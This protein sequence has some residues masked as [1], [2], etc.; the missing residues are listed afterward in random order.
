[1]LLLVNHLCAQLQQPLS[2]VQQL[3]FHR[4]QLLFQPLEALSAGWQQ[5]CQF[6]QSVLND[7]AAPGGVQRQQHMSEW[8]PRAVQLVKNHPE[9]LLVPEGCLQQLL[10]QQ[11][12]LL[13]LSLQEYAAGVVASGCVLQLQVLQARGLEEG[14]LLGR[15]QQ[16]LA[17]GLRSRQELLWLMLD[18]QQLLLLTEQVRGSTGLLGGIS[19]C[20]W[21]LV[22]GAYAANVYC[23][24]TLWLGWCWRWVLCAAATGM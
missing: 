24:C 6:V 13:G 8:H 23:M 22:P 2:E 15:A 20:I 16:L 4:P 7:T 10:Q 9:L 17:C 21:R 11:A 3:A 1:M 18:Q 14:Q 5:V 19:H 12:D